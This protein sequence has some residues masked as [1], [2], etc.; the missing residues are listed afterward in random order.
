VPYRH[1]NNWIP[2]PSTSL[3]TSFAGMTE[4]IG[5]GKEKILT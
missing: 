3:R 4:K 1:I 2:A 5:K